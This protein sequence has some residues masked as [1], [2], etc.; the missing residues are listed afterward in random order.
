MGGNWGLW[1]VGVDGLREEDTLLGLGPTDRSHGHHR[2]EAGLLDVT[3]S[4][5]GQN[6]PSSYFCYFQL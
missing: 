2:E 6:W 5:H 4:A 1:G 3:R